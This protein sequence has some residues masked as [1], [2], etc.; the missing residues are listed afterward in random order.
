MQTIKS[1]QII[2]TKPNPADG[3][4]RTKTPDRVCLLFPP[5]FSLFYFSL[6]LLR[7]GAITAQQPEI[8][9]QTQA[10]SHTHTHFHG[11]GKFWREE[12]KIKG[13]PI[14]LDLRSG[15]HRQ[16]RQHPQRTPT[17]CCCCPGET[18]RYIGVPPKKKKKTTRQPAKVKERL[19]TPQ[20]M[21]ECEHSPIPN[22]TPSAD[23]ETQLQ[24]HLHRCPRRPLHRAAVLR[25]GA[26]FR[27]AFVR[28]QPNTHYII[29]KLSASATGTRNFAQ[30]GTGT[31]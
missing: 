4:R 11:G 19:Y 24:K 22:H 27:S 3:I 18:S 9:S 1:A 2:K 12:G 14:A 29:A 23:A 10:R 28:T 20:C 17:P 31:K 7:F 25:F 5:S 30:K 15:L 13:L 21:Q 16:P 6:G 26:G 8:K